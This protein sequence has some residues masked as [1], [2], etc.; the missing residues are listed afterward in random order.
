LPRAQA[1]LADAVARGADH[2]L[3]VRK[4]KAAAER[5]E[6]IAHEEVVRMFQSRFRG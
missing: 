4:G 2:D 5:G 6:L 1:L 3:W